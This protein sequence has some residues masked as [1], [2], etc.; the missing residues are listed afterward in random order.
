MGKIDSRLTECVRKN[1]GYDT[2]DFEVVDETGQYSFL[3]VDD[4]DETE[5]GEDYEG[6]YFI[7]R[8]GTLDTEPTHDELRKML[9]E[10]RRNEN[11]DDGDHPDIW[12]S[13]FFNV[14]GSNEIKRAY[15]VEN[16]GQ[17]HV[18]VI[19]KLSDHN[20]KTTTKDSE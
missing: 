19:G 17:V 1:W 13:V 3:Y 14:N 2:D 8:V 11:S 7:G 6:N 5:E 10:D 9:K 4:A 20:K 12:T 16:T 18:V 15:Q